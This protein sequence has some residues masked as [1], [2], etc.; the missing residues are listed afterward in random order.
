MADRKQRWLTRADLEGIKEDIRS[1]TTMVFEQRE[2][3]AALERLYQMVRRERTYMVVDFDE[4]SLTT[5][6]DDDHLC[7]GMTELDLARLLIDTD[8]RGLERMLFTR[9]D[10]SKGTLRPAAKHSKHVL[11]TQANTRHMA[12][13]VRAQMIAHQCKTQASS[14]WARTLGE[15]DAEA[16]SM[17]FM[18]QF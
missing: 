11:E 9:I 8:T 13:A 5:D 12:A 4:E 16:V 2:F 3:R 6:D 10:M 17:K 1:S 15:A 7:S 14:I 18:L